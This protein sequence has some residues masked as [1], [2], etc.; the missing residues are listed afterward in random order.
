MHIPCFLTRGVS[1]NIYSAMHV[2]LN[3][4]WTLQW[5]NT[6]RYFLILDSMPKWIFPVVLKWVS[7][8][9]K[10]SRGSIHLKLKQKHSS[11]HSS[12]YRNTHAQIFCMDHLYLFQN[13]CDLPCEYVW[14]LI[15]R[16]IHS[17]VLVFFKIKNHSQLRDIFYKVCTMD[18]VFVILV[19]RSRVSEWWG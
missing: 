18:R 9:D 19:H 8:R 12:K 3:T 17:H 13:R 16:N 6:P 14:C 10:I 2:E 7:I 5:K 4:V 11:L 15:S 1:K